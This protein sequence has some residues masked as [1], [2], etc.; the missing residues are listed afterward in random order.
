MSYMA[1]QSILFCKASLK[2]N[3]ISTAR[4]KIWRMDLFLLGKLAE[5]QIVEEPMIFYGGG[6]VIF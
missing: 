5:Q 1:I 6:Y 4:R 3:E 2:H